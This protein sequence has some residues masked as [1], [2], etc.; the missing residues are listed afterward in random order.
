MDVLRIETVITGDTL[1]LPQLKPFEGKAVEIVVRERIVPDVRPGTSNW[2][3]V[4]AAVMGLT[5]YDFDAWR[6]MREAEVAEAAR[7]PS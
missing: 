3:E 7:D 5:D 4:E 6:E 2:A 1:V